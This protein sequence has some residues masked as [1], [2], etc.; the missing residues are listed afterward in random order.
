M[1]SVVA[2]TRR[3]KRFDGTVRLIWVEARRRGIGE[4]LLRDM[5]AVVSEGETRSTRE[6]SLREKRMLLRRVRGE[7]EAAASECQI[8]AIER[9]WVARL[10]WGWQREFRAWLCGEAG[11]LRDRGR[12]EWVLAHWPTDAERRA[13]RIVVSAAEA[14]RIIEGLRGCWRTVAGVVDVAGEHRRMVRLAMAMER[15]ALDGVLREWERS[16]E[17][18]D[19]E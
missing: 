14:Q 12:G 11:P 16:G 17:F 3:V 2:A 1:V 4:E 10:G 18:H 7:S 9:V 5:A 19:V 6:L 8:W 13:R 15:G